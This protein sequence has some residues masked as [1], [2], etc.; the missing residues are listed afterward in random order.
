VAIHISASLLDD[1]ISCNRKVY[2][3]LSRSDAQVQNREMIIGEVVHKAIEKHWD[4]THDAYALIEDELGQ[5]L[6]FDFDATKFSTMCVDTFFGAFKEYLTVDDGIEIRFK[7]PWEKDVFIVGKMDRIARDC[8]F[9]WKTARTPPKSI[10]NHIQF[11]IYNWAYKKLFDKEPVGVYFASLTSG[12]IIKYK[13]DKRAEDTL[14]SEVIPQAIW[15]I[16]NKEYMRNGM[17]R[18]ACFR[19]PYSG[20]CLKEL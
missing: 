20:T 18:H 15:A 9:D 12:G 7:I 4:D 14:F 6:P 3:R 17:F 2:Y 1:F 5:R 13:Q 10:D 16:K 11:I 8:I 19:C